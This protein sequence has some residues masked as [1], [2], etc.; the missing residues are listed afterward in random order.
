[1]N[2]ATSKFKATGFGKPSVINYSDA[3]AKS[4][5]RKFAS[6]TRTW[7]KI[8]AD[9]MSPDAQ[10]KVITK[11][12][13]PMLPRGGTKSHPGLSAKQEKTPV[14]YGNSTMVGAPKSGD[15]NL[16]DSKDELS[17]KW[18]KQGRYSMDTPSSLPKG[19]RLA[20]KW[21]LS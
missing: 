3:P 15:L 8:G 13:L 5:G 1:M 7:S 21:E 4:A 12:N 6:D 10:S 14:T 20:R 16:S 17:K 9:G 18:H 2:K 11:P 19:G